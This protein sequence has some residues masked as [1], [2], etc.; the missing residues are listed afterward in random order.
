MRHSVLP[1]TPGSSATAVAVLASALVGGGR[2]RWLARVATVFT[3]VVTVYQDP[4]GRG[5]TVAQAACGIL[6]GAALGTIADCFAQRETHAGPASSRCPTLPCPELIRQLRTLVITPRLRP[7]PW[8][9]R[10][11]VS[12]SG[13]RH[14]TISVATA[15]REAPCAGE[16]SPPADE[17]TTLDLRI[18]TP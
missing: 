14:V 9:S 1:P 15:I 11:G 6:F 10:S 13:T 17:D 3:S 12:R 4:C 7:A 8:C 5:G 16:L 18:S 2:G